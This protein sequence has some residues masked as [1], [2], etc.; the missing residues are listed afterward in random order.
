MDTTY[1]LEQLEYWNYIHIHKY[2]R[3]QRFYMPTLA[4]CQD[5][6][7]HLRNKTS[8]KDMD[9]EPMLQDKLECLEYKSMDIKRFFS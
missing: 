3:T 1:A 8:R 6:N 4:I 2:K 7:A 9:Q 5:D